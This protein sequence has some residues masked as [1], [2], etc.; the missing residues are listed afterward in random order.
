MIGLGS[1]N[2][3]C[4]FIYNYVELSFSILWYT[5]Y[6]SGWFLLLRH[7][8]DGFW[9]CHS[10][11]YSTQ[12]VHCDGLWDRDKVKKQFKFDKSIVYLHFGFDF[13]FIDVL[14]N[15]IIWQHLEGG[16]IT[17]AIVQGQWAMI[18]ARLRIFFN[19]FVDSNTNFSGT[20]KRR[21]RS[22]LQAL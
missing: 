7:G 6:I 17:M 13:R 11:I 10:R 5:L 1:D 15:I 9:N 19:P 2:Y 8:P 12:S 21:I 14:Q 4:M 22:S 3:H 16:T 18:M 20:W